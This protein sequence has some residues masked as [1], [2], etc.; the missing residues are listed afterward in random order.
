MAV[1]G[2]IGLG[3]MG[4]PMAG[5][6]V[7]AGHTVKVYNRTH[8]V[9]ERFCG[10]HEGARRAMSPAEAC[11]GA[12]FGIL[13]VGNDDSVRAV[14]LG[15]EGALAGLRPGSVLIDHTTA[16][17]TI[18][19]ELA[20]AAADRDVGSLD[21]PVSG[22]EAGAQNGLLTI[23]C[24]GD[25]PTFDVAEPIMTAYSGTRTLIG[26][27]GTGQ[28]CKMVNQVA[29]AGLVQGLS[30][31]LQLGMSAGL[32]MDRVLATISNGAA[33]SWQMS[34]RGHT[35]VD[36]TFD[37]GFAIEWMVKDLGIA[38]AEAER[39]G[40]PTPVASLVATYYDELVMSGEGRSDTSALIRR[41]R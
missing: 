22:G 28:T 19:H 3:A 33:G 20:S 10:E 34:N 36:D 30:E 4:Y 38:L 17:A 39:L 14:A 40:S 5:H 2:F 6:L 15:P 23:M 16:S 32:D 8:T 18:A 29:I 25:D 12:D 13:I 37:F 21:A 9:A 31:A 1:I 26:P 24:G 11:Q 41:L 35:M 7:T 27:T